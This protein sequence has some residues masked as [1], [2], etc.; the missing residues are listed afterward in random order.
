MQG[1]SYF[2]SVNQQMLWPIRYA[3]QFHDNIPL[4]LP[5]FSCFSVRRYATRRTVKPAFYR[6]S[7]EIW[8]TWELRP[9]TSVPRPIPYIEIDLRNKTTSEFRT[10]F[11]S[12]LV[13]INSQC[14]L[15]LKRAYLIWTCS[16]FTWICGSF[17][18]TD[19]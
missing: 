7:L 4:E 14:S 1:H 13:V 10:V 5:L 3:I 12:P 18:R 6:P 16:V 17:T 11:P 2:E 19:H 8:T 15:Y 9:A